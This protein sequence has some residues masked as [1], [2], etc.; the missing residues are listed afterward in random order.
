MAEL[1]GK[2]VFAQS[3]GPTAVFNTSACGV[4]QEALNNADRFEAVYGAVNGIMGVLHEN[5][6]DLSQEDPAT[7]EGL[8]YTPASTLGTCRR[9]LDETDLERI[10]DVFKAHNIRYFLYNGGNDSMDTAHKVSA[11]ATAAGYEMRVM[12][13]PKTVDNDLV[14]TDHCPGFGSAARFMTLATRY[15]GRDTESGALT[16][17]S[18]TIMEIMGRDAG[19]LTGSTAIGREDER[20]APHLIYLPEV[21]FT[22]D[23]FLDD[24]QKVHDRLGFAV[25]AVS[26]GVRDPDGK[27]LLKSSSVDAFGHVQLGGVGDFLAKLVMDKLKIKARANIPGTI[28]RALISHASPVDLDEAYLVGQMAVKYALEGHNGSMVSLVRTSDTPYAC[29][30]GL[31]PLEK[32]AN[33]AKPVPR[34][35]INADGNDVTEQFLTYVT[36]LVGEMPPNYARFTTQGVGRLLE[37]YT[38]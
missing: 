18:I 31:A 29:T 28:Q 10:L 1:R 9:K 3:G 22:L 4:I 16:T 34:D 24:V 37:A 20:D 11:M 7:I 32:V 26:E 13:I 8:R 35:Y 2:L 15:V 17:T 19:W 36:P 5:M 14:E 27:L 33:A 30:T 6:I 38:H 25:I 21:P 12:G 23:K